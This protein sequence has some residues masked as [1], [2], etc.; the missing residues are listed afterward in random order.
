MA[1]PEHPASIGGAAGGMTAPV[2]S[3]R[4][5][6]CNDVMKATTD[7]TTASVMATSS[8][9]TSRGLNQGGQAAHREPAEDADD[10]DEGV[11]DDERDAA[12]VEPWPQRQRDERR[13]EQE[14]EALR[15]GGLR[16]HPDREVAEP[17][18]DDAVGEDGQA[19]PPSIVIRARV[20]PPGLPD[21]QAG[22]PAQ[23]ERHDRGE[24]PAG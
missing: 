5:M 17:E 15:P 2:A 16:R 19:G 24:R 1:R 23:P 8:M 4:G 18:D 6:R 21:G 12:A 14:D 3:R 7:A 22:E 9:A 20:G 10:S 11:E 13:R